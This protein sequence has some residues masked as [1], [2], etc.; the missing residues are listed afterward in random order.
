MQIERQLDIN[1]DRHFAADDRAI[2]MMD[3]KMD[4]AIALIGQLC[5]NGQTVYYITKQTKRGLKVIEGEYYELLAK[6]M[7][8]VTR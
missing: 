8:M 7:E 5:R 6:A 1:Q 3:R 4:K 2:A